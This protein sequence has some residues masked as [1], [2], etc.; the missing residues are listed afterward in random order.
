MKSLEEIFHRIQEIKKQQKDIRSS[1]KD[2]L[3]TNEQH[4]NISEE[5]SNMREKKKKIELQV[6]EDF[7]AEMQKLEDLNIDLAS[8]MELLS[9]VALN[10]LMQGESIN[11][12]DKDNNKYEPIF[13]VQFK[14]TY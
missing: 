4:V 6:K 14:K 9:D 7:S 3:K 13:K 11:L 12:M 5:L 2:A 1:Y 8:E 10:Q